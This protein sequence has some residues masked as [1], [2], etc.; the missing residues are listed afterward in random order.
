MFKTAGLKIKLSKCQFLKTQF[1]YLGHKISDDRLEPLPMKLK[2]IKNLA[3]TKNMDEAHQ[4]L[5]LL[6]YYR[7]FSPAFAEIT[8]P[9]SKKNVPFVWSKQCQAM[10]DNLKEFFA[11]SQYYNFLILTR[12]ISYIQ[13]LPIMLILVFCVNC[14]ITKMILG[15]LHIFQEPLLP[16]IKVGVPLKKKHTLC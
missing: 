10:L 7:S 2:A 12:I 1:H 9:I 15:Q 5:G 13:T 4:I 14:R 3:P 8:T 16:I 11:V 6:G